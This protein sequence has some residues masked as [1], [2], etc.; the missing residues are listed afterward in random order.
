MTDSR[1][2]TLSPLPGES[3][4]S[5]PPGGG[6]G[7][8]GPL[9]FRK[10]GKKVLVTNEWGSN[11][12][13]TSEAF[14][15]FVGGR[16]RAGDPV[17]EELKAKG[18]LRTGMDFP[19]L[20]EQA[21]RKLNLSWPGPS[22]HTVVVT[23]RCNLKCLYCHASVVGLDDTA[24]DM[25]LETARDTVDFI[26]STPNPELM[27]EFQGG[28]PLLN[29][30]AVRFIVEYARA[31]AAREERS[32][33]IALISNFTLLDEEKLAFLA[34]HGVSFCTSLDGPAAVHDKNRIQ[35]GGA[36]HATVV[37]WIREL[38]KRRAA[39]LAIDPP[40]A[41][42]TI[43]RYSLPHAEAIVDQAAELGLE[44]IQLGPLDPIGFARRSWKTIGYKPEE[45]TAF[46]R[47]AL[48]RIIERSRKGERLYEKMALIFLIRIL[49]GGHWRFPN[50]DGLARLAYNYDGGVYVSEE[51]RLLAN[52]G[53]PFFRLG[54]V[55]QS[56]YTEV[57]A[58]PVLRADLVAAQA[59]AEPLCAQ[60]AYSGYC[61]V[62]PVQN[63]E[64]QGSPWG[65]LPD[66]HWCR[67]LMG[68]FD[69]IFEK[70]AEPETRPVLEGWVREFR[71]R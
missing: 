39:G 3:K 53:D 19:A 1:L 47:R 2:S 4:V 9:N 33:H 54:G 7:I 56:R 69:V 59:A 21:E 62:A 42:A 27:I 51:G 58:H 18:F 64:T 11:A 15:E 5:L 70:L 8:V 35:F 6:E 31:R 24:K 12:F 66:N 55:G 36:C 67:T 44:R 10:V 68:L 30:P 25:T 50:G 17:F 34:G 13:L 43:T 23:L 22:V 38:Q 14:T 29:W 48:E 32:V 63:Y 46:Y 71:D 20:A 16:L 61:T 41:I 28:E 52:E 49:E 65:R 57:M 45:F 26:F 60:C 40:N 37:G